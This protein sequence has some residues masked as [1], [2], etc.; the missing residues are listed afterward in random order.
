MFKTL[1]NFVSILCF[2]FLGYFL[3]TN[4]STRHQEDPSKIKI[5]FDLKVMDKVKNQPLGGFFVYLFDEKPKEREISN[6]VFSDVDNPGNYK[7]TVFGK[8][9]GEPEKIIAAA[10]AFGKVDVKIKF[11]Y[12]VFDAK[13]NVFYSP[14]QP[15]DTTLSVSANEIGREIQK[16][17]YRIVPIE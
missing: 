8:Y 16:L 11:Y 1:T 7:F 10:N 4:F 9:V 14:D 2:I 3:F 17:I 13:K 15:I 12:T 6:R 5:T